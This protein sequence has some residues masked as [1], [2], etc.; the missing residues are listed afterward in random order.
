MDEHSITIARYAL[1]TFQIRDALGHLYRS[2]DAPAAA[3]M[4]VCRRRHRGHHQQLRLRAVIRVQTREH[5]ET[6]EVPVDALAPPRQ[7]PIQYLL[8]CLE[9]GEPV[10]GPLDPTLCR[11][12]QQIVDTAVESAKQKRTLALLR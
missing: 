4:R 9:T 1:R 11:I 3:E 2:L 12:G 10:R 5:P 6:H 8:H 7:N